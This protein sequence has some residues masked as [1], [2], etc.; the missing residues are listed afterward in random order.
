MSQNLIR[1]LVNEVWMNIL[2]VGI[3]CQVEVMNICE[4][5]MVLGLEKKAANC[6][7][8]GV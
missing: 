3:G 7:N 2:N 1:Y 5:K 8:L 4:R 6:E